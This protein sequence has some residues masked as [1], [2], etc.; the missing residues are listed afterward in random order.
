M[1]ID[2]LLVIVGAAMVLFGADRLTD[3]A[4]AL[5]RK[6]NISEMVIGLTIV[7]FG[8][9]MPEFVISL[10]SAAK[11]SADMAVGNVVGSNIF[12]T[13]FIVGLS[14]LVCPIMVKPVSIRRDVP[15]AVF[16]T[17]LLLVLMRN[18]EL[19]TLDG[20]LLIAVFIVFMIV[21]V[22]GAKTEKSVSANDADTDTTE[23]AVNQ[24]PAWK[25][26]LWLVAGLA[27]LI[28]GSDIFVDAATGIAKSLNIS[29]G[30]IGL[31]I[32]ALGTSL[33]ELATSVVAAKKGSAD[34]AIGNVLGSNVFNILWILGFTS[35]VCPMRIE[36]ITAIDMTVMGA[37]MLLLWLFAFTKYKIE[38]WEGA[39]MSLL[40]IGYITYLIATL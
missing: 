21:T 14:A 32:V 4:S 16:A 31:T 37:S 19:S 20:A 2:L 36:S 9:S 8:T 25:S 6:M 40:F 28:W 38:R 3:S 11:D 13:L 1:M 18:A 27:L 26:T 35:I 33:P 17:I 15:F 5:A 24:A 39:V 30:V 22:R 10:M 34:M 7:A 29:D 12:N 23:S